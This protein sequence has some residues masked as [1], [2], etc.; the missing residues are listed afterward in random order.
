MTHKKNFIS[1][2]IPVYNGANFLAQTVAHVL[3][4]KYYPLEIIVIDDGSTD[5]TAEIA[6]QLNDQI[7][8][9]YQENSGPAAARNMGIKK[10]KGKI[11]AFLDVDDRWSNNSLHLL[12]KYLDNHPQVGIVQGMIVKQT[13]GQDTQEIVKTSPPYNF[14][15]LGCGLYRKSV[16]DQVGLFDENMRFGEDV[17]WYMRAWEQRIY[18]G[19]ID[20]V[21]L[22]YRMHENNMT[23]GKSLVELGFIRIYKRRLDRVRQE[24][25]NLKPLPKN[26]P[27]SQEYLAGEPTVHLKNPEFTIISNNSWS[28]AV[29]RRLNYLYQT[30]FVGTQIPDECYSRLIANL[31]EYVNSPLNFVTETQYGFTSES[32]EE[33]MPIIGLLGKDVEIHFYQENTEQEV[34]ENWQ[35]RIAKINWENLHVCYCCSDR[36]AKEKQVKY[37]QEFEELDLISKVA[38]TSLPFP[39]YQTAVYL[40]EYTNHGYELFKVTAKN[41]GIIDWLNKTRGYSTQEYAI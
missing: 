12:T 31:Q 35:K 40:P 19:I 13:I 3:E 39:Q 16:F 17:D 32:D 27:T 29:Y 14:I 15:N 4:Q 11:I 21:T 36:L 22:Y 30:P 26:F 23:K 34:L 37:L 38:F 7:S 8:Y 2:I 24:Q 10:A 6:A 28:N 18:K 25:I 5:N 33:K 1:V 20:E 41:F 9:F